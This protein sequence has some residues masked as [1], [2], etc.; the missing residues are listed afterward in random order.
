MVE[1]IFICKLIIFIY[2]DILW[3]M[4]FVNEILKWCI[5]DVDGIRN[6][7]FFRNGNCK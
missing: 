1:L 4:I 6:K 2:K 3:E 5:G 7:I